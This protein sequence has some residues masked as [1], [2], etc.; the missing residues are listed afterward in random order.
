MGSSI[1]TIMSNASSAEWLFI[2]HPDFWSE[3][4]CLE[5]LTGW[6]SPYHTASS[7]KYYQQRPLDDGNT[8][9]DCSFVFQWKGETVAAFIG[10][11][12]TVNGIINL[13]AYEMPCYWIEH[14]ERLSRKAT[15]I[16]FERLECLVNQAKGEVWLKDF[17]ING[18]L[19]SLSQYL[20]LKGGTAGPRFSRVIDLQNDTARIKNNIRKSYTSLVNW[21]LRELK[22]TVFTAETLSW[23]QMLEFRELHIREAGRVTRSSASWHRQYESVLK[24]EAF[25]VLGYLDNALVSAGLFSCS[26]V[27]CYY[28]V[29]ASRR[30]LFKKP[31]FHAILWTAI[32]HA[33]ERGCLWFEVGEQLFENHPD[34]SPPTKKEL[35]ISLFKSGFGG[36]VR[37]YMD[38]LLNH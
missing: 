22:P 34:K 23:R 16:L 35:D 21:G 8:L 5:Q 11:L 30:D 31:L 15:K 9:Q 37:V 7:L 24:G 13:R 26:Q 33:K 1:E 3:L 12:V 17:L 10:A 29:S 14:P 25:V 4:V 28:G 38:V 19:S 20:L 18:E 32:L 27:A 6:A 2:D 36:G